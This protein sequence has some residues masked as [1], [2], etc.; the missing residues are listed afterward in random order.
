M[1][2]PN[3]RIELGE[4]CLR[5]LGKPVININV[6]PEQVEDRIDEALQ[7]FSENHFDGS[8]KTWLAYQVT[9]TDVT[10]GYVT[11]PET[12]MNVTD[13]VYVTK[14]GGMFSYDYQIALSNISPFQPMDTLNYYMTMNNIDSINNMVNA[15]QRISYTKHMNKLELFSNGSLVEGNVIGLRVYLDIDPDTNTNIYNDTWLKKYLT[16]LIKKQWGENMKKHSDIQMLGGI[17]VNGQ[18][19]YDEADSAIEMLEEELEEKYGD[20]NDFIIG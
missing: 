7:L 3:T 2:R 4:W 17:T 8:E 20:T 14:S 13:I 15:D 11:L 9:A 12:I 19:I 1:G 10:N 16:Q 5:K 6:A 18:Q